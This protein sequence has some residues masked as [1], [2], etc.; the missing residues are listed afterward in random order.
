MG[1]SES[2][3]KLLFKASI[4]FLLAIVIFFYG[5]AVGMLRFPPY[6][7]IQAIYTGAKSIVKFGEVV[8]DYLLIKSL[9]DSSREHFVIQNPELMIEGYYMF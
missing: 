5:I 2:L 6:K 8:P 4:A 3:E 1:K 9:D 7:T